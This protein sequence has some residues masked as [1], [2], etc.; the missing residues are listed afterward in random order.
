MKIILKTCV[1]VG[2]AAVAAE[3]FLLLESLERR[4]PR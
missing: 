2:I 3:A 1:P 4:I